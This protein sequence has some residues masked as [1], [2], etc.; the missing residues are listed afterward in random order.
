[1][2]EHELILRAIKEQGITPFALAKQAQ[3][4]RQIVYKYINDANYKITA[5]SLLKIA[6]V[7]DIELKQNEVFY[8]KNKKGLFLSKYGIKDY[9]FVEQFKDATKF[10]SESD[11]ESEKKK[12]KL[13]GLTIVNK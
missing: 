13:L 7:L 1:M 4:P 3:I 10:H 9:A 2:N 6:K 12:S 5:D 11:A 8:L